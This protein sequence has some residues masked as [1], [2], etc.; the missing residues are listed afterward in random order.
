MYQ[1]VLLEIDD[2]VATITLNRPEKLN[3]LTD[4]TIQELRHAFATAEQSERVVGIVLTGAGRGFCAGVD[5]G[6][7]ATI[8]QAGEIAAMRTE[9][10]LDP[11]VPGDQGM[12]PEFSGGLTYLMTVRKPVIA[13]INGAAAGMG[14]SLAMFCDLRFAAEEAALITAYAQR[15]LVAEHGMSWVLPRLI[16]PSRALDLLWSGRRLS[17]REAESL[18]L[19][20]RVLPSERL[21]EEAREYVRTLATTAAP[22][23]LM[24][25][26]QQVYRH[27]MQPLGEAMRE[28]DRL[29]DDSIKRP[30][31]KE[32]I[33]AFVERRA[34]RF[35]RLV[36]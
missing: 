12:G 7:L 29:V 31:F 9:T 30:D 34:P 28:T 6:A 16:G 13:A 36:V 11:L 20:N 27:L 35:A 32:G 14:F 19:V 8:Q 18:G 10:D 24:Q 2:P 5:M 15:G 25:M 21:L 26:K 4:R 1:E 17:A 33:A 23:S 3:A 22:A